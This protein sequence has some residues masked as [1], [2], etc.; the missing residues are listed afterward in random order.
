MF[1]KQLTHNYERYNIAKETIEKMPIKYLLS[2]VMITE[3]DLETELKNNSE[4]LKNLIMLMARDVTR[5]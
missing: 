4:K 1:K 5:E 3:D 2:S